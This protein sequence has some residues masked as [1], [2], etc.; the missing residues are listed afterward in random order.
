MTSNQP[1]D[2][3]QVLKVPQVCNDQDVKKAY[4][5]LV[6]KWHPDVNK[7]PD[8]VEQF[9]RI[10]EAYDMLK[11]EVRRSHYRAEL[12]SRAM[13]MK[14]SNSTTPFDSYHQNYQHQSKEKSFSDRLRAAYSSSHSSSRSGFRRVVS[15]MFLFGGP[16]LGVGT[17]MWLITNQNKNPLEAQRKS[18]K[19]DGDFV[20]AWFN[21]K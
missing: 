8:A 4:L 17:I 10:S 18:L 5:M 3:F 20:E 12:Q 21:P 2:H 11:D 9:K 6:K 13:N 14:F 19:E 1:I 15:T 7:T 16:I